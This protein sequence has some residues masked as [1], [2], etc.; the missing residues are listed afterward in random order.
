[1]PADCQEQYRN[2]VQRM[3]RLIPVI[4][5]SRMSKPSLKNGQHIRKSGGSVMSMLFYIDRNPLYSQTRTFSSRQLI[6]NR[7]G[8]AA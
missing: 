1:M 4:L 8:G 3:R 7:P 6:R 5:I 2:T